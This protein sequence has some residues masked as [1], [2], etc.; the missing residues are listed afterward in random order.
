MRIRT[1]LLIVLLAY[2]IRLGM[3][4]TE[5]DVY[6]VGDNTPLVIACLDESYTHMGRGQTFQVC[7][8]EDRTFIYS[9]TSAIDSTFYRQQVRK[10]KDSLLT[11]F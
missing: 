3:V 6:D 11:T 2:V 1:L 9:H 4:A 10:M 5:P 8:K 7:L